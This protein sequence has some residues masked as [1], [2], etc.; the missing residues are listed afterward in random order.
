ML[1]IDN[2]K[3]GYGQLNVL[4]D[5]SLEVEQGTA[6]ALIG[7]NGAGKTTLLRTISGLIRPTQGSIFFNNEEI[8]IAKPENIVK[9]G[10]MHVPEGRLIFAP[11]SVEDNLILGTYAIRKKGNEKVIQD[12]LNHVYGLF[13]R[14]Y[15]RKTQKAGTLSGGEQQM[16]AIGRALMGSP[17]MLL[18]D[19]PSL[20]LS[21]I[22][23]ETVYDS[24]EHLKQEGLPML[25]VEQNVY[26]GLSFTEKGYII[27]DGRIVASDNS[28]T[29]LENPKVQESYLSR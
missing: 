26:L 4:W 2:L 17:K 27:E 29:L 20:G 16:L 15:E 24:L 1:K 23:V 7:P 6:I 12:N 21:P 22:A 3:A 8:S 19:E 10:L 9:K 14:L 11:L 28:R 5:V 25:I 18:L 13:P